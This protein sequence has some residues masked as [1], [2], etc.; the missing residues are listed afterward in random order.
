[1]KIVFGLL[2][3][4]FLGLQYQLWFGDSGVAAI[5]KLRQTIATQA[6]INH[7][8]SQRNEVLIADIKD[9]RHGNQAIEERAREELGMIKKG[10]TF[11]RIVDVS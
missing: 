1:M 11:Y 7:Q 6:D 4:I 5:V 2:G 10:E 3:L 9:L 8:L